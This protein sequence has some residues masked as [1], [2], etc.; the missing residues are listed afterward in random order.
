MTE[1]TKYQQIKMYL[2]V[3]G[4]SS[5]KELAADWGVHENSIRDFC[6]GKFTSPKL[7][8]LTKQFIKAGDQQ[9]QEHR[10]KKVTAN[11]N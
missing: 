9:F 11:S 5:L 4:Y 3:N 2:P 1:I 6:R 7:D 10:E 8:R